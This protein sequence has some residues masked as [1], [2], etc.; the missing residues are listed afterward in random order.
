MKSII[1]V[2][3]ATTALASFLP[4]AHAQIFRAYL[5]LTGLDTNPCTAAAP[6]RLLPAALNAVAAGGEVWMLDSANYNAGTVTILK[7]VS[8][9][10]APGKIGSIVSVGGAAA[11]VIPVTSTRVT[12]RNIF[13]SDNASNHGTNGIELSGGAAL[14]LDSCV[15]ANIQN[16]GVRVDGPSSLEVRDTVFRKIPNAVFARTGTNVTIT[17]TDFLANQTAVY[18][19]SNSASF[20]TNVTLADSVVSGNSSSAIWAFT[21]V[22]GASATIDISR[23]TIDHNL[24]GI[25]AYGIAGNAT[26]TVSGSTMVANSSNYYQ[27][28][29]GTIFTMGNNLVADAPQGEVGTLTPVSLQ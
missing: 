19:E 8:I 28:T 11:M 21:W 12:L 10:A 24:A 16:M 4:A 29:H 13:V 15:F 25:E 22:A 7:S 3:I 20:P 27:G 6:C 18:A 2:F 26:I 23:S 1:R 17:R 5:S 14:I 9:V